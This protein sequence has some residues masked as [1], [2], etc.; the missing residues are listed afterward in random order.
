MPCDGQEIAEENDR[1]RPV[2]SHTRRDPR[3]HRREDGGGGREDFVGAHTAAPNSPLPER[4]A[5]STKESSFASPLVARRGAHH[6][7][8][9][10]I[11]GPAGA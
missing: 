8:V 6:K 4:A 2:V 11:C 5:R 7:T 1:P 3:T 10:P 9:A